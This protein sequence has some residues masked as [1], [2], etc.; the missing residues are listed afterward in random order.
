[1]DTGNAAWML[2]SC[3]LVLLMTP[4]LALFYGGMSRQKS[5]LNMMMMSFGAASV[6]SVLYVLWGWS[7]SYGESLWGVIGKPW[8]AFGLRGVL[9]V[10]GDPIIGSHGYP[11]VIDVAFQLTF[12]IISVAL[13]SGAL[14]ERVRF[15]TWMVFAGCW[16]T[17]VYFPVAHMVWNKGLLSDAQHSL[18]SWMFGSESGAANVV[19]IDFAGGVVVHIT[20]GTA[21]LVLALVVGQR[22]TWPHRPHNLPMVM[23]GASLL[24]FGWFGFNAGSAFAADGFAGLAW[25]NTTLAAAVGMASWLLVERFRDGHATSLGAASGVVAGL[26]AITP[27]AGVVTPVSALVIGAG[28]GVVA[29]YGV[30]LKFRFRF[31]DSLDV[32]GVHLLAGLWGTLAVGLAAHGRGIL[33]GGGREGLK[34]LLIQAIIALVAMAWSAIWSLL[35][36]ITL[37]KTMGWRVN[38]EAEYEGIDQTL[39]AESA[40]ERSH[41]RYE[42]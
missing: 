36:A 40:Y 41:D 19:P 10:Q 20:A 23:L 16:V 38:R 18:A 17:L 5:V 15:S 2:I 35:I 22:A 7:I 39:H 21:A 14:A 37:K 42:R 13:I 4:S 11:L 27:A 6:V 25:M 34:L 12:A 32:V 1:M 33:S 9:D 30:G 3:S 24:W 28:G 31:D 26:V 8:S 29:A